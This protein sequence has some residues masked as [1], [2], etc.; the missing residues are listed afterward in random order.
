MTI[1]AD[2]D[3]PDTDPWV[4]DSA[5]FGMSQLQGRKLSDKD[6][7][8]P[9]FDGIKRLAIGELTLEYKNAKQRLCRCAGVK[10]S[11][12]ALAEIRNA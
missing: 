8:T 11:A 4:L 1:I 10:D 12:T 2:P 9:G 7:T 5:A 3:V 6:A